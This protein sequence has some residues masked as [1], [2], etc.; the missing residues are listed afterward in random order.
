MKVDDI[1]ETETMIT[2]LM[3]DEIRERKELITAYLNN[4][5]LNDLDI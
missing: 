2:A 5:D 4:I 1:V 3:G